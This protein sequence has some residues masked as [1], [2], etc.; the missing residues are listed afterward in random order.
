MGR[1]SFR[2]EAWLVYLLAC[3][4]VTV[5][6]ILQL[7]SWN[8]TLFDT[9]IYLD[10]TAKTLN[11][12]A[13]LYEGRFGDGWPFTYPPFAVLA[14]AP[15]AAL[16]RSV[17]TGLLTLGSLVA[18]FR[19]CWLLADR[20]IAQWR[21]GERAPA[22]GLATGALTPLAAAGG[23]LL[24][25]RSDAVGG[26]LAFGQIN[27]VMAWFVVEDYLGLGRRRLAGARLSGMLTGL[28]AG[29]KVTPAL[30][31]VPRLFTRDDASALRALGA[32]VV[33]VV[34]S[35]IVLPHEVVT[36][37]T[38]ALWDTSRP[39]APESEWNQSL[40]GLVARVMHDVPGAGLVRLLVI[41]AALV[42]GVF[43]TAALLRRDDDVGAVLVIFVTTGA[44]SPVT[45]YHHLVLAPLFAVWAILATR[46]WAKGLYPAIA[47]QAFLLGL[48]VLTG[49]YQSVPRDNGSELHHDPL[50]TV[51]SEAVPVL[52]L[53]IL[54]TLA[55]AIA[56]SRRATQPHPT[57]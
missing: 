43:V 19:I 13:D 36:Y 12:T 38:S 34:V 4:C 39:G 54:L 8:W 44:V 6:A 11:G 9:R 23:V 25:A 35:T 20:S 37:F 22:P 50:E 47:A 42:A 14:F 56:R 46:G 30:A 33:T 27:L 17:A 29:V 31:A 52:S 45:W 2:R 5:S 10:A 21:L 32:G 1:R 15:L 51:I 7:R 41:A 26:T 16:A 3:A 57:R 24:A 49:M 48:W 40:S 53:T 28:A 55:A 18:L